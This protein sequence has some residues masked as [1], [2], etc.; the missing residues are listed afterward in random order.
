MVMVQAPVVRNGI[1]HHCWYLCHFLPPLGDD[2]L[3]VAY[4]IA[5]Q[6]QYSDDYDNQR[7]CRSHHSHRCCGHSRAVAARFE[8]VMPLRLPLLPVLHLKC[9][10]RYDFHSSSFVLLLRHFGHSDLDDYDS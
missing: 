1:P 4:K 3:P 6:L 7:C 2:I 10:Y 9:S 5:H 8:V